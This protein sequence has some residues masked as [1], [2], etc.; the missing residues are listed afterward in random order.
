MKFSGSYLNNDVEFLLKIIDIGFTNIEDKEYLI[1]NGKAHY[2]ELINQEYEPS[3]LYIDTF[4]KVFELNKQQFANDILTFAYNLNKQQDIILVSLVRAGTPIGV[5]LKRTL[6]EIFKRNISHYSISIIR[7]RGIDEVAL[8][9]ILK[10]HP[11]SKIIFIDGW[12]GKGVINRELKKFIKLYNHKNTTTINDELYVVSDIAG[13]AD[14]SINNKDYLIPSSALNS[15]I[16][17]LVSRS[18][19]NSKYTKNNDF[20]GCK[21]YK[22]YQ[23]SDLSLWFIE[24]LI[25]IIK[26]LKIKKNN[27]VIKNNTLNKETNHYIAQIMKKYDIKDINYIKP[28]MGESTR[29]LLRRVPFV[30]IVKDIKSLS[31]EHILQL[32]KEKKV[33]VIEDKNLPYTALSIIKNISESKSAK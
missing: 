14:F 20:H 30:V 6:K 33:K 12:T 3:Q 24:N 25:E 8:N 26:G 17:G 19:L 31:I 4:Y 27:F 11:N 21:Y 22:E 32:A 9:Y 1:Q 2:S 29:V 7:D 16:S 28:G 23:K 13:V 18:I 10:K 5:L 15:T